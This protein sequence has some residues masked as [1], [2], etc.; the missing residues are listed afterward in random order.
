VELQGRLSVGAEL[1]HG[2]ECLELGDAG[3]SHKQNLSL[4][5]HKTIGLMSQSRQQFASVARSGEFRAAI[6]TLVRARLN[7]I[8]PR[9]A[10]GP[11]T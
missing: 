10:K 8:S 1:G 7:R 11:L 2:H 5:A 3:E 6:W 4:Y 9:K